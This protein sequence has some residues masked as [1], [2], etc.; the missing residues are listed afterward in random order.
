MNQR[1]RTLA[2]AVGLLLVGVVL[3]YGTTRIASVLT[4]RAATI[5]TLDE[6][7]TST[8][9]QQLRGAKARK[10]L[11]EYSRRALPGNENLANTR[12]RQ[13]LHDWVESAGITGADVKW[14]TRQ[15]VKHENERAH[16][17][18]RFWVICEGQLPQLV[19]RKTTCTALR[20]Y[21][22]DRSRIR[23]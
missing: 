6:E 1:E 9:Q 16:D 14:V 11:D 10:L 15:T 23:G 22:R 13:W 5:Q 21:V 7:I 18:H 19:T 20:N 12:Y 2:I 8:E 17:V 3:Y 4:S